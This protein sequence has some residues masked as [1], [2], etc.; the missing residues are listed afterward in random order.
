LAGAGPMAGGAD[1]HA[2]DRGDPPYAARERDSSY[3][4]RATRP[5]F[6][7]RFGF[8]QSR[9]VTPRPGN[10]PFLFERRVPARKFV[11]AVAGCGFLGCLPWRVPVSS[12]S[13]GKRS[14]GDQE[15]SLSSRFR[16]SGQ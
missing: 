1:R 15:L 6:W 3:L 14:V 10:S 13:D 7:D 8:R 9:P 12:F 11:I 4:P 16:P 2:A 5:D